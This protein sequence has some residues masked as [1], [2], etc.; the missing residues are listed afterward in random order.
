MLKKTQKPKTRSPTN[1]NTTL[2]EAGG[3]RGRG[4]VDNG[5]HFGGQPVPDEHDLVHLPEAGTEAG[6]HSDV[7]PA[8]AGKRGH[9]DAA[10]AEEETGHQLRQPALALP[11]QVRGR[12]WFVPGRTHGLP[13]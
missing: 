6:G 3:D 13:G 8:A 5:R 12:G 2:H 9:A 7:V 1:D 11:S 10:I 4:D